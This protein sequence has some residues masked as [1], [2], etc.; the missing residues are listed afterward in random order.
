[1]RFT[2]KDAMSMDKFKHLQLVAGKNGLNREIVKIGI[3]DYEF[4]KST[5]SSYI[6]GEFVTTSFLYAKDDESKILEAVKKLDDCG[7]SGLAVKKVFFDELPKAVIDYANIHRLPIFMF[8]VPIYFED[9]IVEFSNTVR[10]FSDYSKYEHLVENILANDYSEKETETLAKEI[11]SNVKKN[12]FF[13]YINSIEELSASDSMDML[14]KFKS[15]LPP[16]SCA[17]K[18]RTGFLVV[19]SFNSLYDVASLKIVNETLEN[20]EISAEDY[21]IGISNKYSTFASYK[22]AIIEAITSSKLCPLKEVNVI[23]YSE[24]GVLAILLPALENQA[25]MDYSDSVITKIRKYDE[26]NNT[27]LLETATKYVLCG[28]SIKQTAHEL[29]QHENTIR[30]RINK[31]KTFF[32]NTSSEYLFFEEL[33]IVIQINMLKKYFDK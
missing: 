1:M 28:G 13:A 17:I 26:E 9:L 32:F 5:E 23:R 3:L 18:Y 33:A 25:I 7:I 20:M 16:F 11:H 29:F 14:L 19:Y 31:I 21:Y 2:V 24:L 4:I 8:E 10:T 27:D 6:K 12:F 22:S 30:Y 15:V